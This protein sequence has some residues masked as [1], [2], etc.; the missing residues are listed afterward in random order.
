LSI[1]S[2]SNSKIAPQVHGFDRKGDGSTAFDFRAFVDSVQVRG[3]PN[4]R[5]E[6]FG[7][8]D[9]QITPLVALIWTSA[10]TI[11]LSNK[12]R[13]SDLSDQQIGLPQES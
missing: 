11:L 6:S 5:V 8:P 1:Q 9:D 4:D 2:N 12:L 10:Q 13:G 7:A 3:E